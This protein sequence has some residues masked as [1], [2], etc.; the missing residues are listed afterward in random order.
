MATTKKGIYYPTDYTKPADVPDDMKKLA[1]SVDEAIG[2]IPQY[3]DTGI[4]KDISDL[5]KEQSTQKQQI[6]DNSKKNTQ[7]DTEISKLQ[8]RI[9]QLQ[10]NMINETTDEATSLH[11]TNS[12]ELPARLEIRGNHKQEVTDNSPSMEYPSE[13]ETVGDNINIFDGETETGGYSANTGNK[14]PPDPATIRNVNFINV[15]NLNTVMFSCDGESIAMNVFEYDTDKTFIK[16]TFNAVDNP[17]ELDENTAFINFSRSNNIETSKIKIEQGSKVTPYSPY[18]QGSVGVTKTN[19][20]VMPIVNLGTDWEYT[21]TGIKNLSSNSGKTITRLNLKKGQIIKF[22]FKLF[23]KPSLSTTFTFYVDG[24]ENVISSFSSFNNYT[25]NQLY[26]KTY[27]AT[28]D[29]KITITLW[30]NDFGGSNYSIFEFQLWANLEEQEDYVQYAEENYALPIQKPMLQGDYFIKEADGWKEVHIWNKHIFTGN[31][32]T[33]YYN[34]PNTEKANTFDTAYFTVQTSKTGIAT[35]AIGTVV[36]NM[37]KNI[38][39]GIQIWGTSFSQSPDESIAVDST[40]RFRIKKSQL[41][42]FSNDLT[43]T[44]KA[45]LF[46][47]FL[48]QKNTEGNP[49]YAYYKVATPTK[50]LCTEAQSAVLDQISELPLNKG[51]NNVTADDLALLQMTYTVDTKAYI[52]SKLGSEG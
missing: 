36:S 39:S 14:N 28:E 51:I 4:K 8:T 26:Q 42:N 19:S 17:F 13:V 50:L 32:T 9:Q 12:A 30:G 25:L 46:K 38:Y 31:E 45:N 43:A 44:E 18:G 34:A 22:G 29:C 23:S 48:Q 15:E 1:E 2:N 37:F 16:M 7:Q 5:K 52:D 35:G 11:V 40:I 20:N 6:S 33:T 41:S 21:E 24:K 49:V 27:T 3:D 10:A 47:Q